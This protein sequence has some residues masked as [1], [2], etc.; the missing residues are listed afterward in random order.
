M[1]QVRT[2]TI[3]GIGFGLFAT[4]DYDKWEFV[5]EYGGVKIT[6][7]DHNANRSEYVLKGF[8]GELWDASI[9]LYPFSEQGRW[10][11]DARGTTNQYNTFWRSGDDRSPRVVTMA[12]VA[13]GQ[14]FFINYG[15]EYWKHRED[16]PMKRKELDKPY[17]W[18]SQSRD[19]LST[20]DFFDHEKK[21]KQVFGLLIDK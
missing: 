17:E 19:D 6:E 1:T 3:P 12:P 11:N 18:K 15:E 9:V 20:K 16:D 10:I 4:R 5:T 2:S 21:M 14:E 8:D 13:A 7:E